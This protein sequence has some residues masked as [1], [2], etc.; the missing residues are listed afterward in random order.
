[1]L[2]PSVAAGGALL[3]TPLQWRQAG[4]A[5]EVTTEHG[6]FGITQ[7]QGQF[8]DVQRVLCRCCWAISSLSPQQ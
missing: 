2:V 7:M 3:L 1:V 4:P 5:L 8:G 6:D